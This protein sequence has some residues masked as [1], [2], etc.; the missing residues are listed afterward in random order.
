MQ[1][2][3]QTYI[4]ATGITNP[5]VINGLDEFVTNLKAKNLW[6]KIDYLFPMVD[7][8]A[9][10]NLKNIS[11]TLVDLASGSTITNTFDKGIKF[12]APATLGTG[13]NYDTI[14]TP[15]SIPYLTSCR[16]SN[17]HLF[18]FANL[19]TNFKTNATFIHETVPTGQNINDYKDFRTVLGSDRLYFSLGRY[20]YEYSYGDSVN[21]ITDYNKSQGLFGFRFNTK[22]NLFAYGHKYQFEVDGIDQS[23]STYTNPDG[24]ATLGSLGANSSPFTM[25]YFSMGNKEMTDQDM[26]EYGYIVNKLMKDVLNIQEFEL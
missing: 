10:K 19:F 2:E 12:T 20:N 23:G 24:F 5:I 22:L 25:S 9:I 8:L 26:I 7:I 4:T 13:G 21:R 15:I 1:K 16:N 3:T 17:G 6:K 18:F 14:K 11:E